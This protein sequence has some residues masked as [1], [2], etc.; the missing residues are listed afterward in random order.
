MGAVEGPGTEL[1]GHIA[2]IAV[3]PEFRRTGAANRLLDHFEEV[4]ERVFDCYFVDLFVRPSNTAVS[5]FTR[6]LATSST[7]QCRSPV[8]QRRSTTCE[9]RWHVMRSRSPS[10]AQ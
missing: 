5:P 7:E 2:V 9:S 10:W 4:S 8:L 1:H 6:A 3:A